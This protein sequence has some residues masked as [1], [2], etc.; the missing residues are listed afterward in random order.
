VGR[1]AGTTWA[2]GPHNLGLL[3][4][5]KVVPDP[6][7]F[8]CP[9]GKK[10]EGGYTHRYYAEVAPWPFGVDLSK[11][12]SNPDVVRAGCSYIPQSRTKESNARGVATI[13][14]LNFQKVGTQTYHVVKQAQ[15][16]VTKSMCTDLIHSI[17]PA[18]APHFQKGV[19]GVNALFGD[20]HVVYQDG[21]RNPEPFEIWQSGL[22]AQK[23]REII[24][25][26]EP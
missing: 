26:F 23:V 25:L 22:T 4:D 14:K 10:Y 19:P 11:A 3:W 20:G 8:Y 18:S 9:S 15:L 1:L 21:R 6:E 7:V 12:P 13:P 17:G 2:S 5:T 16:D 24:V